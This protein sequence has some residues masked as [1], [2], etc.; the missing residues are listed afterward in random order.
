MNKLNMPLFG[1]KFSPKKTPMRRSASLNNLNKLDHAVREAEYGMEFGP[2]A[3]NLGNHKLVFENG[4]WVEDGSPG[5]ADQ[6]EF[7]KIK[8]QNQALSEENNL[9]KLKIEVLLDM[10]AET[11]AES[12]LSH[13]KFEELR[14]GSGRVKD[15][16]KHTGFGG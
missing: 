6:R 12:H 14:G 3:V 13:K 15:S 1:D 10:L 5:G 11:T 4:T 16:K 9:L 7:N 2:A 8:K